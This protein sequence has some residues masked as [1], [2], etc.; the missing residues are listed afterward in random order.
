MAQPVAYLRKSRVTT[1]STL[2]WE[3]QEQKVRDLA[4]QHG[5]GDNLLLLSDW[6]KSGRK[7]VNGRPGYH[8]LVKMIGDGAVRAVYSYNL[9]RLSRSLSDFSKLME[10]CVERKVP[11]HLAADQSYDFNTPTGRFAIN[12][13]M[14]AAQMEAEVAQERSRH[15]VA[16]RRARGDRIGQLPYGERE[17]EDLV[18]VLEAYRD[19]GSVIG[20]ARLLNVRG[21]PT[22]GGR[23]WGTTPVRE[24]LIRH[25][26][27]PWRSRPG[28]KAAAPFVLFRLLRCHCGRQMTGARYRNGPDPTYT[29][30]RCIGGRTDVKHVRQSVSERKL[31]PWV[32]A[33]AARFRVPVDQVEVELRDESRR[34]ELEARRNGLLDLVGTFDKAEIQRRVARVDDE[35]A[36][37]GSTQALRVVPQA[38]DWE[39]WT[40][41]DINAVLRVYW[42]YLELDEQMQPVRAEWRLP[43]EY[44]R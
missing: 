37:L 2:S 28:Q 29:V 14:S 3:V 4:A 16:A 9:S 24:I 26:A 17:G 13:M 8:Q 20:A 23:Q 19:A 25:K 10:L 34:L 39:T 35:I 30:Y 38:I 11:I 7:G 32:K 6:N 44:V 36:Q 27:M 40:P 12:V 5:D 21:V 33:E 41:K 1:E 43:A 15:V 18:A 22:R 31:L 42:E